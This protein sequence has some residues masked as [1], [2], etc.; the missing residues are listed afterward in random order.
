MNL[1]ISE[2]IQ[3]VRSRLDELS[4]QESELLV[5]TVDNLNLD[6]TIVSLLEEAV[7]YVHQTAPASL[8]EGPTLTQ[9]DLQGSWSVNNGIID[10]NLEGAKEDALRLISFKAGDSDVKLTTTVYEDSPIGRMQH[11][12][13]V[14]GQPDNPVL[15]ML[16]DSP[17]YRPHLKYYTTDLTEKDMS[18]VLRYFPLPVIRTYSISL[19]QTAI[20]YLGSGGAKTLSIFTEGSWKVQGVPS[21][22]I[23]SEVN[24]IGN[25]KITVTTTLNTTGSERNA[26]LYFITDQGQAI[27]E[28]IQHRKSSTG[29]TVPGYEDGLDF[30]FVESTNAI[31]GKVNIAAT[32]GNSYEFMVYASVGLNWTVMLDGKTSENGQS[33]YNDWLSITPALGTGIGPE[34]YTKVNVSVRSSNTSPEARNATLTF[35][36]LSSNDALQVDYIIS[37]N[38][39][40]S[41]V[42]AEG[43]IPSTGGTIEVTITSAIDWTAKM[44]T[45]VGEESIGVQPS[46]GKAGIS[47]MYVYA[48]RNTGSERSFI[49]QINAGAAE[50]YGSVNQLAMGQTSENVNN[51]TLTPSLISFAADGSCDEAKDDNGYVT[52][53]L[54]YNSTEY[55]F[56]SSGIPSWLHIIKGDRAISVKVDKNNTSS[57]R[58]HTIEVSLVSDSSIKSYL[59]IEQATSVTEGT[60]SIAFNDNKTI[61]GTHMLSFSSSEDYSYISEVRA[62]NN[63]NFISGETIVVE[64]PSNIAWLGE[65]G[66]INNKS[67]EVTSGGGIWFSAATGNVSDRNAIVTCYPKNYPA[68]KSELLIVQIGSNSSQSKR[69]TLSPR[70]VTAAASDTKQR[71]SISSNESWSLTITGNASFSETESLKTLT[72]TGDANLDVYFPVN[73]SSTSTKTYTISGS[74][75]SG[76]TSSLV[77]TQSAAVGTASIKLNTN[78]ATIDA[79]GGVI[80]VILT[81]NVSW[82]VLNPYSRVTI[83]PSSGSAVT[84]EEISITIPAI[85]VT[86]K[87]ITY[88]IFFRSLDGDASAMLTIVQTRAESDENFISLSK[89][90]ISLPYTLSGEDIT[91][92]A[93]GEYFLASKTSWLNVFADGNVL[94]VGD[95]STSSNLNVTAILNHA[96]RREGTV[97][98]ALVGNPEKTATLTVIQA[99][100]PSQMLSIMPTGTTNN[101]GT[102][103]LFAD[104]AWKITDIS[105]ELTI[106]PTS[107][108]GNAT[109]DFSAEINPYT[110]ARTLQ[111]TFITTDSAKSSTFNVYQSAGV[112][113]VDP[114]IVQFSGNAK[115]VEV[116][117]YS[118]A[119]WKITSLPEWVMCD[120]A[121]GFAA[122]EGTTLTF[123]I[124]DVVNELEGNI[125]IQNIITSEILTIKAIQF[126]DVDDTYI[127]LTP[128]GTI[129]VTDRASILVEVIS[130]RDWTA[131]YLGGTATQLSGVANIAKK[132]GLVPDVPIGAWQSRSYFTVNAGYVSASLE[133]I[134]TKKVTDE[135]I[136]SVTDDKDDNTE[137]GPEN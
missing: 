102:I 115:T 23:L 133:V 39:I 106:E 137:I 33:I 60:W 111:A 123:T 52:V 7:S 71:F 43:A 4:I 58:T 104:R 117:L 135:T 101:S 100:N 114:E 49:Y 92:Q 35:I 131:K 103:E 13:Y 108:T 12:R 136:D 105:P 10:I 59:I 68:Y 129:E 54:D 6:E 112:F 27:V 91:I 42:Q 81:S 41:V 125:T 28:I 29:V 113:Y 19:D 14:Q 70:T 110:T 56:D 126:T 38:G 96:Q 134:Y 90:I 95:T 75:S 48:G 121:A 44:L 82:S 36:S 64:I 1:Y 51:I 83:N 99:Q 120:V 32:A 55:S 109:L 17:N 15:V 21:W 50:Y 132:V 127:T 53:N 22:I 57:I 18:F 31:N 80:N 88:N 46:N 84:G 20:T 11:N 72:G 66:A 86:D 85:T 37:Q 97:V 8:M 122:P 40:L 2:A 124:S 30:L 65:Y 98:L 5:N 78:S 62:Y 16:D 130:N 119:P 24:G 74:S 45:D 34:D 93:S 67:F 25:K 79:S 87:D 3:F 73:T 116:T 77:I 107:G 61:G 9:D 128:S 26:T 89:S 47:K 118:S 94:K 69:F 63:S 76:L